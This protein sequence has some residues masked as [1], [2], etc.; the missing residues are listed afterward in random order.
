MKNLF[1]IIAILCMTSVTF[2]QTVVEKKEVITTN[3][4]E[5]ENIQDV[6]TTLSEKLRT[7]LK[8]EGKLNKTDIV[9]LKELLDAINQTQQAENRYNEI[10]IKSTNP[11]DNTSI[12]Y[13]LSIAPDEEIEIIEGIKDLDLSELQEKLTELSVSISNSDDIQLLVKKLK[14]K[15]MIVIEEI[16]EKKEKTKH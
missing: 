3:A 13:A 5:K 7:K 16:E 8:E 4:Q 9:T 15:E 11:S 2:A 10:S 6:I 1:A 12:S 14:K